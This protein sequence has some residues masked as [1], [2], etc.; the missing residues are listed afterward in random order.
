MAKPR[1]PKASQFLTDDGMHN[2]MRQWALAQ[3]RPTLRVEATFSDD[4]DDVFTCTFDPWKKSVEYRLA[5]G[6][7]YGQD[8]DTHQY[9]LWLV[10]HPVGVTELK[11]RVTEWLSE[12]LREGV[13][14]TSIKWTKE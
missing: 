9:E 2:A 13:T 7:V 1:K 11:R 12:C 8:V 10:D 5:D 3:K 4:N 6:E 14:V